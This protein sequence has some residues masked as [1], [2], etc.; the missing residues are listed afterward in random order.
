MAPFTLHSFP[1][2][3]IHIDADAFFVSCEVAKNPSLRGKPVITGAERG[4]ASAMSY[5]AKARGVTRA[6][7]VSEIKKVCPDVIILPS[8]YE[9]YS[10]YSKRM[11]SIVRRYTTQVEEYSI[12]ECFAD[13]TGLRRP[14]RMSYEAIAERIKRDLETELGITFSFGLAP[15]KVLAKVASKWKKPA[16]LTVIPARDAHVFLAQLGAGKV[17]GIGP[18][19]E[20]HLLKHGVKTALD[21]AQ[22]S[23]AWVTQNLTKPHQEIWHE[24]RG[25]AVY[26]LVTEEKHDYQSISK[27]KTFTPPSKDRAFVF[28]QL[29]K[30]IEN[31]CI[32]ARRH[33]LASQEAHCFLKTQEFRYRGITLTLSRPTSAPQEIIALVKERFPALFQ[34]GVLYRATGVVLGKLSEP[35]GSQ[36]DLFGSAIHAERIDEVNKALDRLDAKYGKHTVF[37]GSS[38]SALTTPTHHGARGGTTQRF[39][40]IFKGETK[41]QHLRIPMLGEAH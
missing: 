27:T 40:N 16:G 15:S 17:W 18:Q 25:T 21:F 2:A 6:M 34:P 23:E 29:S 12:D 22:K 3:I 33:N 4:I 11:N 36:L 19:T 9:T 5:E 32:K 1:R 31:A 37:L 10:L 26:E 24:L 13:I 39:A 8:D 14:L 7:K 30:N 38:L 20:A 35:R 41:R 28:S